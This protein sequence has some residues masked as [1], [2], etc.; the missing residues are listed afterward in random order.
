MTIFQQLIVNLKV[1]KEPNL[2]KL[3]NEALEFS[4]INNIRE[5]ILEVNS[6]LEIADHLSQKGQNA[7]YERLVDRDLD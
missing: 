4:K 3:L 6:A 5:L 1:S 2:T 7:F